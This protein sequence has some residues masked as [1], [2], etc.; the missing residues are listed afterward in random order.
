MIV[1]HLMGLSRSSIAVFLRGRKPTWPV[2][3][4]ARQW[5]PVVIVNP[6]IIRAVVF[7]PVV[8]SPWPCIRRFGRAP[9]GQ[10]HLRL[11]RPGNRWT[12]PAPETFATH[13]TTP[14]PSWDFYLTLML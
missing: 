13:G 12:G 8:V 4:V 2:V 7:V 14:C 10:Y 5:D 6:V 9:L 11:D 1:E 3:I